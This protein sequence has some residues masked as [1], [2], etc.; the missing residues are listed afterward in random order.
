VP[1]NLPPD[2]PRLDEAA[3]PQLASAE[4][5]PAGA[6]GT[7]AAPDAATSADPAGV[8]VPATAT[9][10]P[11]TTDDSRGGLA[12]GASSTRSPADAA[13]HGDKVLVSAVAGGLEGRGAGMRATMLARYGGSPASEAAVARG[14]RWLAVHQRAD[15]SWH[16]NHQ[17]DNCHGYCGNP[18]TFPSTTAATGLALL[19]FLGAGQTHQSGQYRDTVNKGILYLAE[20]MIVGEQGGDLHETSMYGQGIATIALCE[21]YALT[22]DEALKPYAQSALDFI[23]HGQDKKG[24]GWRYMPNEPG[25]TTV[26]GWQL[27][28]L[29]SGVLAGLSV[30]NETF[31]LMSQFLDSVQTDYGAGYGYQKPGKGPTTS[32]IGVLGRMLTGWQREQPALTTGVLRLQK[33]GPSKSDMYFNYYATQVLRHNGGPG[34]DAWNKIMREQLIAG[35]AA[36]GHA[37]G[38][39]FAKDEHGEVGG[40]LYMTAMSIMTLEVYYRYMPLY[41]PRAAGEQ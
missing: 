22:K 15:G 36:G 39:W 19:P 26:T 34:W 11:A 3:P 18:G 28:A 5:A 31:L 6:P 35:Q 20:Q 21:A 30:P 9:L 29:K 10:L 23:V 16:F 12:T 33:L 40:R 4:P 32:A 24:G 1:D 38:S 17:G 7:G 14:L 27:L 13:G 41:Q 37:T 2:G 25:D 8:A